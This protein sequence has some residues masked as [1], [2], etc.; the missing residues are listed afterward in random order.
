[1]FVHGCGSR[2]KPIDGSKAVGKKQAKN[3]R[4]FDQASAVPYRYRDGRLEFCLITSSTRRK[5]AF[6]K[7]V[8]GKGESPAQTALK[9]AAE[10]AG[11]KGEIC[12]KPLGK[13]QYSK[14]GRSLTVVVMLMKVRK[15]AARW[16]E[17][18]IRERQWVAADEAATFVD[19]PRLRRILREAVKR[20]DQGAA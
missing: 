3:G 18:D 14:F 4:P 17:A 6:P 20:L 7:G 16:D 11:L 10:E 2:W 1:M 13:Y 5:W 9:E 19:R 8:I 12:G 15:A